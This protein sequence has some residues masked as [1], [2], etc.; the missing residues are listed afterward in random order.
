MKRLN[1]NFDQRSFENKLDPA[2]FDLCLAGV[3]LAGRALPF[4]QRHQIVLEVD[5]CGTDK[6][7]SLL[8][9]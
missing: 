2:Y 7:I 1:K 4:D 3:A 8:H 5:I 6:K 9:D